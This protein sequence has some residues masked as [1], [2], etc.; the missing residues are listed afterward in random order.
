MEKIPYI[1]TIGDR[2]EKSE[3]LAV[4]HKEKVT[5]IKREEFI[6]KILKEREERK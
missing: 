3:T 6:K 2:E 5:S 4:R 1:V